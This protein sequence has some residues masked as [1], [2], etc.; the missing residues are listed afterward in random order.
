MDKK[1]SRIVVVVIAIFV[2]LAMYLTLSTGRRVQFDSGYQLVM[3]TFARVVV[4][5]GDDA[6][7]NECIR[8]ALTEIKN[9]DELMSD[10]KSDS[11]IGLVNKNAAEEPV[12]V[13]ESTFEVLQ[14]SIEFSEL[15]DGAFDITVG[16]LVNLWGF[17]PSE[18]RPEKP[19][20]D[21]IKEKLAHVGHEKFEI[22]T[23]RIAIRKIDP[24]TEID[25]SGIATDF[26][27]TSAASDI[28]AD[29]TVN[30]VDLA[31]AAAN[32]GQSSPVPWP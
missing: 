28:N 10:Y 20:T 13:G 6:T 21:S 18:R 2:I 8:L 11:E 24:E 29:G 9:V 16:G 27:T 1:N 26:G 31:G 22:D 23:D 19:R 25:V 17:G 5:A 7:A 4:V 12:V 15:T 30:I 14:K 32:F 3:G